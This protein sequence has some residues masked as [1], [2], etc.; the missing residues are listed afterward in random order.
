MNTT[1][2][3]DQTKTFEEDDADEIR[4][5]ICFVEKSEEASISPRRRWVKPCKCKTSLK[6]CHEECLL[7]WVSEKQ[8]IFGEQVNCPACAH[9]Y[10]IKETH[11]YVLAALTFVDKLTHAVVPYITLGGITSVLYIAATTHGAHTIM[12]LCGPKVGEQILSDAHWGWRT[13]MGLPLIP[14]SLIA[15]RLTI[16]DPLLPFLPFL[17]LGNEQIRISFPPSPALTMCLLPWVRLI[18]YNGAHHAMR[19]YVLPPKKVTVPVRGRPDVN[20]D[21]GA[22]NNNNPAANNNGPANNN[23]GDGV[24]INEAGGNGGAGQLGGDPRPQNGN[25]GPENL[26]GPVDAAVNNDPELVGEDQVVVIPRGNSQRLIVGA[27]L[28]PAMSSL[29]GSFLGLFP[30]IRSKL[31]DSFHRNLLG[32]FLVILIKDSTSLLYQSRKLTSKKTRHICDYNE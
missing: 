26:M 30:Y 14:V 8:G 2:T 9:P 6:F 25:A 5:W 29:A 11:D 20:A 32:G 23:A 7:A 12:T 21:I 31:T 18:L 17:A 22:G 15:S 1:T 19:G 16:A 4:C 10:K 3:K 13:W 24:A 28:F 27:L